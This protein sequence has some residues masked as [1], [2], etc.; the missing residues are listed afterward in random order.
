MKPARPNRSRGL[1]TNE[2]QQL[3]SEIALRPKHP[4][5]FRLCTLYKQPKQ[6]PPAGPDGRWPLLALWWRR[7]LQAFVYLKVVSEFTRRFELARLKHSR[8]LKTSEQHNPKS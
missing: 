1:K 3:K 4:S 2:Q 6:P 5:A 7:G 8:G